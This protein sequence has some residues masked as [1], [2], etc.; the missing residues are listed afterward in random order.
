MTLDHEQFIG[1]DETMI[2]TTRNANQP[3]ITRSRLKRNDAATQV[4]A[5]SNAPAYVPRSRLAWLAL[6]TFALGTESLVM[7]VCSHRWQQIEQLASTIQ[8]TPQKETT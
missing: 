1:H 7:A 4:I 8:L 2:T 3:L 5:A 6:G